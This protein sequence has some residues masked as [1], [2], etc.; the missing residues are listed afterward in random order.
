[1]PP[2]YGNSGRVSGL[3]RRLPCRGD[4]DRVWFDRKR[5]V[6]V[7]RGKCRDAGACVRAARARGS[8]GDDRGRGVLEARGLT[9]LQLKTTRLALSALTLFAACSDLALCWPEPGKIRRR[10]G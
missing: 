7:S 3:P 2:Y 9:E 8:V 6:P 5:A 1:M 4:G 10:S